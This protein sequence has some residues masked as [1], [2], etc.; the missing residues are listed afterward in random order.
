MYMSVKYT[1]T[2]NSLYKTLYSWKFAQFF[3]SMNKA[4]KNSLWPVYI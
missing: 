1:Y 2:P 3:M 4:T